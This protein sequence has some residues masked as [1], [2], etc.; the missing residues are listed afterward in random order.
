VAAQYDVV[1]WSNEHF[2]L[3]AASFRELGR[4]GNCWVN[5]PVLRNTEFGNRDDS[6]I[7]WT[8]KRDGTYAFDF[9]VLDRYLDLAIQHCGP[10]KVVCLVVMHG[11]PP[12]ALGNVTT[13]PESLVF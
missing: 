12:R 13:A 6:M 2:A 8:L 4:I 1:P 7:R 10:P 9:G 11:M 5:V 3:L